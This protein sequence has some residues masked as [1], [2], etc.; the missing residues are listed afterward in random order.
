MRKKE[1]IFYKKSVFKKFVAIVLVF[2][3]LFSCTPYISVNAQEIVDNNDIFE[4]ISGYDLALIVVSSLQNGDKA[5]IA[6]EYDIVQE[7]GSY[8]GKSYGYAV[9]EKPYGYAVYDQTKK[10]IVE[11]KFQEGQ[12]NIY[13]ELCD[14]LDAENDEIVDGLIVSDDNPYC[15][16]ALDKDGNTADNFDSSETVADVEEVE[17]TLG[18]AKTASSSHSTENDYHFDNKS[19]LKPFYKNRYGKKMYSGYKEEYLKTFNQGNVQA[20]TGNKYAC[21]VVAA[22]FA[23]S[24]QGRIYK[25]TWNAYNEIYQ[26]AKVVDGGTVGDDV[27]KS[28]NI[29]YQKHYKSNGFKA[30]YDDTKVRFADVK[31]C[32]DNDYKSMLGL[33]TEDNGHSV[34]VLGYYS[35][36]FTKEYAVDYVIIST[37]WYDDCEM[38]FDSV[39]LNEGEMDSEADLTYMKPYVYQ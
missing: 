36:F 28:L 4:E 30:Y 7:D 27:K 25:N 1:N 10:R 21:E 18:Y 2:T 12:K 32:V 9:D 16:I 17:E 31:N 39:Y 8:F 26:N 24:M 5:Y 3:Y 23:L 15:L 37:D 29:Y 33:Y 22:T 35:Y 20:N 38:Y 6:N 11:F 14:K 13:H 34:P 19:K